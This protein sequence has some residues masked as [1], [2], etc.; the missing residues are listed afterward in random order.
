MQPSQLSSMTPNQALSIAMAL[1]SNNG[2]I[3]SPQMAIS[4]GALI[5]S[6]QPL[7]QIASIASSV[8]L[9]CF[10]NTNSATLCNLIGTMDTNNMSP[11][12]KAYIGSK[13]Y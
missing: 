1:T 4:I 9:I 10:N 11:S 5:A 3:L 13:V 8:P 6:N 2:Q 7:D 12:R